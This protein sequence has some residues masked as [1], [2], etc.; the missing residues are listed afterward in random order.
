[1]TRRSSRTLRSAPV[2]ALFFVTACGRGTKLPAADAPGEKAQVVAR[3]GAESRLENPRAVAVDAQKNVWVAD[4]GNARILKF[5]PSGKELLVVGRKGT[6]EGEFQNPW[7]AALDEKGRIFV[8]DPQ[9][10]W[11]QGFGSDGKLAARLGGPTSGLYGPQ[12]IA[13]GKD[14]TVLV[15]D[16]GGNRIVRY[17]EDG[18]Q[19]GSP[20][21]SVGKRNLSQPTDVVLDGKGG[22][23]IVALPEKGSTPAI[24]KAR[25]S[26]EA[27]GE[28]E[29]PAPP[30][31]RD[32]VR[33][34]PAPDG[35]VYATDPERKRLLVYSAD[36]G[37]IRQLVLPAETFRA[38]GGGIAVDADGFLYVADPVGNVVLKIQIAK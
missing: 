21:T 2:L 22:V 20:W 28:W 30:S 15:A 1:M 17:A 7:W 29:A 26:G 18:T 14:G 25:E 11:I 31:T 36:G 37:T 12:G 19:K 4:S 35:R 34:A 27:A 23:L 24:L 38:L 3:I 16:T 33:V 6:G 8:V 13:V 32:S 9:T 5:D 10:G